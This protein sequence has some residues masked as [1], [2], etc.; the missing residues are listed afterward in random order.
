VLTDNFLVE[1]APVAVANGASGAITRPECIAYSPCGAFRAVGNSTDRSVAFFQSQ[2]D[3][4]GYF[5]DVPVSVLRHEKALN[6]VHGVQFSPDGKTLLV[7]GRNS[8]MFAIFERKTGQVCE[9]HSEPAFTLSG[10]GHGLRFPTGVTLSPDG[11]WL[12][13]ANRIPETGLSFYECA[14]RVPLQF[15]HLP[16]YTLNATVFAP[17]DLSGPQDVTFSPDGQWLLVSHDLFYLAED[18]R[19]QPGISLFRWPGNPGGLSPANPDIVQ[20]IPYRAH[21]VAFHPNSSLFGVTISDGGT[22]FYRVLKNPGRIQ[23]VGQLPS[24]AKPDSGGDKAIGFPQNG[25]EVEISNMNDEIVV[26]HLCRERLRSL[27]A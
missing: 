13:V 1:Q 11:Q 16:E 2:E 22:Q 14:S 23:Q 3:G 25:E 12:V 4:S 21:S 24:R 20:Q 9:F 7:V 18:K 5:G 19:G 6:Y 10:R 8:H 15:V 27:S 17:H 26:H